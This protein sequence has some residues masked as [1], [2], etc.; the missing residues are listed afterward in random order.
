MAVPERLQ[1]I[2]ARAGLASRREAEKMIAEGRVSVNGIIVRQLGTK[3]DIEKDSI[4]LNGELVFS[5]QEKLY[6]MLNKP[7]GYVST[8]RD[9]QGRPVV[10]ELLYGISERVFPVGRLDYDSEGLLLMTNDGDFAQK[11]LHPSFRIPKVYR[12]KIKGRLSPSEL[13]ALRKGVKLDDGL[14][15]PEEVGAARVNQKTSWIVMTVREGR[16]RIIRRGMTFLG[17]DVARLIRTRIGGLELGDL[18]TGEHRLLTKKE[19]QGL[20]SFPKKYS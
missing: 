6:I 17:Y 15:K 16:N 19:V 18:K 7:P 10:T 8:L 20:F 13:S 9:P 5:E 2:I 12:V 1:K 14:F 11:I 3:A 4:R